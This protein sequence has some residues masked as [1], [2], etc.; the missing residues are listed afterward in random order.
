MWEKVR[1]MYT[2]D[3][4]NGPRTS[5]RWMLR[6]KECGFLAATKEIAKKHSHVL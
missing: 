3:R 5:V 1:T 4:S 2:V 6:C